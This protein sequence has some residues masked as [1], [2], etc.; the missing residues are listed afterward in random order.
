MIGKFERKKKEWEI[1]RLRKRER[2]IGKEKK[3]VP[4]A[5]RNDMKRSCAFF[6]LMLITNFISSVVWWASVKVLSMHSTESVVLLLLLLL[7]LLLQHVCEC[8]SVSDWMNV[9][10]SS[11]YRMH[12]G[13]VMGDYFYFLLCRLGLD[14]Y[15]QLHLRLRLWQ[16]GNNRWQTSELAK[17]SIE[18][19]KKLLIIIII[20]ENCTSIDIQPFNA[21]NLCTDSKQ[22]HIHSRGITLHFA[23]KCFF[24]KCSD[25]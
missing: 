9:Q 20:S 10:R 19:I 16:Y 12:T 11:T 8:E 5:L 14:R 3:K 6:M 2:E 22:G 18:T 23:L 17:T 25:R 13:R 7:L 1:E 4:Q 15:V 24:F 21:L